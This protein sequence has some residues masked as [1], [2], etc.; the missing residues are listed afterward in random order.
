VRLSIT[1]TPRLSFTD[2][3]LHCTTVAFKRMLSMHMA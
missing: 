2:T 1:S 3:T